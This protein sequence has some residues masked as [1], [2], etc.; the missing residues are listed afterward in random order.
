MLTAG[1]QVRI[2]D[3][4][5]DRKYDKSST[6]FLAASTTVPP[7]NCHISD[8]LSSNLSFT[9]MTVNIALIASIND[10]NPYSKKTEIPI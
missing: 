3:R 4:I 1:S 6:A 5:E 8:G 9:L 10:A 7:A 2:K